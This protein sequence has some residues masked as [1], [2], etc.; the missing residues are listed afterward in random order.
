[1]SDAA[2]ARPLCSLLRQLVSSDSN[3]AL[4]V[5]AGGLEL[6]ASLLAAQGSNPAVL[7]QALG[8][9]TNLTLRNPEAASKVRCSVMPWG[10]VRCGAAHGVRCRA[11]LP[12]VFL[13]ADCVPSCAVACLQPLTRHPR[14]YL[15]IVASSMQALDCGCL[16]AVLELMRVMLASVN[17]KENR[18]STNA[19]RQACMALR[20]IAAR[21]A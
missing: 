21:W 8:M 20:N 4:L 19:Q 6:L 2:V 10:A 7:E 16:D 15:C 1:M 5:E 12:P 11:V 17:G 9:L 18:A 14:F 3:K 13:A